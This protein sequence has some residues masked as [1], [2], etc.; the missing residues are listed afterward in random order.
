MY[1]GEHLLVSYLRGS[2]HG[3]T[4]HSLAILKLLVKG[5]RKHWPQI[6]IVFRGDAGFY[7]SRLL[8]WCEAHE[9]GYIVGYS[10]NAR[11]R[12]HIEKPLF[13]LATMY[14]SE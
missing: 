1:C 4:Y 5:I 8:S 14:E 12:K 10:G 9:V 3:D 6:N 13:I 11:L 2:D 7:Q